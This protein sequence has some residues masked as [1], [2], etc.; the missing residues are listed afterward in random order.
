M[1]LF[2]RK[3][4][5]AKQGRPV[6]GR[7]TNQPAPPP[8][9]PPLPPPLRYPPPPPPSSRVSPPPRPVAR[10]VI[11]I[12]IET[13]FLLGP[14]PHRPR[15]ES[16]VENL[17]VSRPHSTWKLVDDP[18]VGTNSIPW[19]VEMVSPMFQL[20]Q[21]SGWRET[22]TDTWETLDAH[23]IVSGG[24]NCSTHVHMSIGGYY[25][26]L[27]LKRLAQAIIHFEPAFEAILPRDRRGNE[28]A[29]SNWIDND[30]FGR[31][32]LSRPQAVARIEQCRTIDEIIE[33]MNPKG[34]RY[35]GWNFQALKKYETVEFR[36]GPVSTTVNDV[37]KWIALAS[38]FLRA[39]IE[40]DSA[41]KICA[42]APTVGGL[43]TFVYYGARHDPQDGRYLQ[44]LLAGR[45]AGDR[46]DPIAVGKLSP[47]KR[48]KLERKMEIDR[49]CNPMVDNIIAA[50]EGRA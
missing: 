32:G 31:K 37:F 35:F 11:G 12:G 33:L 34:S 43:G 46:M 20:A 23:Y 49:R 1:G 41:E 50:Q 7:Q 5:P 38:S 15:M 22:I 10:G 48:K 40:M 25:S 42:T 26:V 17:T 19:G 3:K 24:E 14:H 8:P 21:S 36:R 39:A 47:E 18:T 29:R 27:Q 4:S 30:Y 6:A 13:E 2:D 9:A 45:H 44:L 16:L 28:Y